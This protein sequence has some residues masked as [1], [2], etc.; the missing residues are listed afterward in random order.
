MQNKQIPKQGSV[1]LQGKGPLRDSASRLS[2]PL[3]SGAW[4]LRAVSLL[5]P[6]G[7]AAGPSGFAWLG[8]GETHCAL[9]LLPTAG[10]LT[11]TSHMVP[12]ERK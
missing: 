9:S 1:T 5:T 8:L 4:R 3:S 7:A 6:T 10:W 12:V 2:R 11:G